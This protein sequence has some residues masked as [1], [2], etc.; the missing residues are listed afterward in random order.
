MAKKP[1]T[2]AIVN[3]DA[4]LAKQA[5]VAAG[6]ES[7]TAGG[8]FFSLRGGQL[9]FDGA[10]LP[11]NQMAVVV[12]DGILENVYYAGKYD[13]DE[14]SGPACFAFGR[15]EKSMKPHAAVASIQ[16]TTCAECPQNEWASADTGRGKACRNTRRLA[17]IPAGGFNNNTGKFEAI[18]DA[19]HYATAQIAFLRLPVTSVKAYAATVKQVAAALKRP[20]HGVFMKFKVTPDA[21]TQFRVT[22]EPLAQVPNEL[23]A[24]IMQRHEEA[25]G[26]I[27]FAY[28]ASEPTESK[29][30]K[31]AAPKGKRKY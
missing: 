1:E 14:V 26:L 24:T 6:M 16:S 3:W 9:T 2:T 23:M 18:D 12:L 5:E 28:S 22:V 25:K 20:P 30:K 11:N 10:P 4:E 15:D 31:S 19:T 7:S 27:E 13:P 17:L 29:N 8:T 21:K